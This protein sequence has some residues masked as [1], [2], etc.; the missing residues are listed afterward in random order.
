MINDNV[1][2]DITSDL[3]VL[4]IKIMYLLR[5][6]NVSLTK[7]GMLQAFARRGISS[8]SVRLHAVPPGHLLGPSANTSITR[9]GWICTLQGC[10]DL[11]RIAPTNANSRWSLRRAGTDLTGSEMCH[12]S[13]RSKTTCY[14]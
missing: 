10:R 7:N 12:D 2:L 11:N 6:Y 8:L 3:L 14:G 4:R 5:N 1:H 9:R 13:A